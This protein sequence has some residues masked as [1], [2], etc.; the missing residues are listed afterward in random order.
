MGYTKNYEDWSSILHLLSGKAFNHLE[1]QYDYSKSDADIHNH[2]TRYYTKTLADSTFFTL[3]N[4]LTLE[5]D[6][7]KLDGQHYSDLLS[8]TLPIGA[9][10][11]WSGSDLD[12]PTNWHI[13]DG[14]TYESILSPDL[15]NRFVPGAGNTYANG[16]NG[17]VG[18]CLE[19]ASYNSSNF[20]VIG[21][22]NCIWQN[23]S[24]QLSSTTVKKISVASDGTIYAINYSDGACLKW[25]GSTWINLAGVLIEVAAFSVTIVYGIGDDNTLWKCDNGTWSQVSTTQIK[26]LSIASDG[27]IYAIDY[28]SGNALKWTGSSWSN[29]GGTCLEIAAYDSSIFYII[30]TDSC[31]YKYNLGFT[32]LS[33]TTTERISISSNNILLAIDLGIKTILKWNTSSP[34]W[35]NLGN[36]AVWNGT[37]IP[38]ATLT[39]ADHILS[40]LELPEHNHTFNDIHTGAITRD[41]LGSGSPYPAGDGTFNQDSSHVGGSGAHGH[42]GSTISFSAIDPRPKYYSLYYIIKYR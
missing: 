18:L 42:P 22:D 34:E 40:L 7:D 11:A 32:K 13:C 29:L 28:T 4:S 31:I 16:S 12:I 24:F 23:N 30:G 20:Y 41:T 10:L 14:G 15:R 26:K 17:G 21:N 27:T 8:S 5:M 37:V 39:I 38:T 35:I 33:N 19:V 36:P 9:I 6:A 3:V 1:T 2:D 25:T